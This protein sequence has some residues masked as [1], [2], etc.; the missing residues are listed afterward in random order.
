MVTCDSCFYK[1]I[2][3]Y[4]ITVT[5]P[6]NIPSNGAIEIKYPNGLIPREN[7]CRNSLSE[8]SELSQTGLVCLYDGTNKAFV[9]TGFTKFIGPGKIVIRIRMENPATAA[10][11][12]GTWS[13]NTWYLYETP[14]NKL[15]TYGTTNNPALTDYTDIPYWDTPYRSRT[16]ARTT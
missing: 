8:G 15:I 11:I 16:R 7:G 12:T 6:K 9:I 2:T 1:K 10:E 4:V 5:N 13:F 3:D 14:F